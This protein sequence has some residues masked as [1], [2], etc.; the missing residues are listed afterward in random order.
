[1][2][3]VDGVSIA[4]DA[5]SLFLYLLSHLISSATVWGSLLHLTHEGTDGGGQVTWESGDSV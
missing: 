4:W 1:M 5:L 2:C 3:C